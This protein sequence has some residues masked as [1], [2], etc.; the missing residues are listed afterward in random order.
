MTKLQKYYE[1]K[2]IDIGFELDNWGAGEGECYFR[3][4]PEPTP[5]Q[6]SENNTLIDDIMSVAILPIDETLES[7]QRAFPK[8][9]IQLSTTRGIWNDA[10]KLFFKNSPSNQEEE[11]HAIDIYDNE[12]HFY[13]TQIISG[14]TTDNQTSAA[15]I[16]CSEAYV[17]SRTSQVKPLVKELVI[18]PSMDIWYEINRKD[19]PDKKH[20]EK[21]QRLEHALML[22]I[23]RAYLKKFPNCECQTGE[24]YFPVKLT[25]DSKTMSQDQSI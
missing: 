24:P 2:S 23:E 12:N 10:L 1:T 5:Q 20:I 9:K 7:L 17:R 11:Y 13:P 22:P 3:N 14:T 15:F 6:I 16:P 19:N 18:R 8:A 4:Y 21:L 25:N